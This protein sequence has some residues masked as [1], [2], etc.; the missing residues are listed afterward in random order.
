ML[1]NDREVIDTG[2]CRLSFPLCGHRL[3]SPKVVVDSAC[4]AQTFSYPF[5][6]KSDSL[7]TFE[8]K[9]T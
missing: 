3:I 8:R 1:V 9:D 2:E 7:R 6:R 4:V 5:E